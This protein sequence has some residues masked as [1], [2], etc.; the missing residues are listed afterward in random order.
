MVDNA[1]EGG[2]TIER[3]GQL[4][5]ATAVST[6]RPATA[7]PAGTQPGQRRLG[8]EWIRGSR[9]RPHRHATR[10]RPG[11]HDHLE[12]RR[13]AGGVRCVGLSGPLCLLG[14]IDGP[15]GLQRTY[16]VIASARVDVAD[17][18]GTSGGESVE[19]K[20]PGMVHVG[21]RTVHR[22]VYIFNYQVQY[23]ESPSLVGPEPLR[24]VTGPGN[25][26]C[27]PGIAGLAHARVTLSWAVHRAR[28]SRQRAASHTFAA[29]ASTSPGSSGG[30]TPVSAP[31]VA[32]RFVCRAVT[33]PA[34]WH[35]P[36]PA[37][38]CCGG[39]SAN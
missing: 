17:R 30:D 7:F 27:V 18:G 28:Y 14:G 13:E 2:A 37:L 22:T 23:D 24:K 12:E 19:G 9:G 39:G 26:P 10:P 35:T 29:A 1:D 36:V 11:Q 21:G 15:G 38:Q 16:R 25:L 31:S 32:I 33:A 34:A 6:S 5:T 3:C 8:G 4:T 20:P